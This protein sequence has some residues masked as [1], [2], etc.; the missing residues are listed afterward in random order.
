MQ[1]T[2]T[3]REKTPGPAPASP[4]TQPARQRTA[5]ADSI[6][7]QRYRVAL[8]C[9]RISVHQPV[10]H[11]IVDMLI[12][13]RWLDPADSEDRAKIAD[14]IFRLLTDMAMSTRGQ[15]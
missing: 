3:D 5:N 9:D 11:E 10:S 8:R 7:K 4:D 15:T 6:R 12:D 1:Q 14:A 13:A 2:V